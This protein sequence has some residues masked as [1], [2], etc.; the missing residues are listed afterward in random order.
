MPPWNVYVCEESYK[1]EE[2]D[3]GFIYFFK[4]V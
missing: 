3:W 4:R 2:E 1:E